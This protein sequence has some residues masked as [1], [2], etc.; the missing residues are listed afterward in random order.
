MRKVNFYTMDGVKEIEGKIIGKMGN[1]WIFKSS[2]GEE[3]IRVLDRYKNE[4]L[5]KSVDA[6]THIGM[7]AAEYAQYQEQLSE[8]DEQP[9][10]M[11]YQM[12]KMRKGE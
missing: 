8:F 10:R 12:H 9:Q 7:S 3:Y 6:C 1:T 5:I 4:Y 2:D 11:T